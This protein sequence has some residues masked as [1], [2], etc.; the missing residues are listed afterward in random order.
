MWPVP[1]MI[2]IWLAPESPWWLLRRGRTNEAKKS[3]RR[4]TAR[5]G[6]VPFKPDETISMMI[7]T[8]EMEK[9][10]QAGTSY[11]DLFKGVNLRRA[12]IVCVTWMIQT[13]CAAIFMGSL[14]G[15]R[16]RKSISL[17]MKMQDPNKE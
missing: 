8:N 7:H 1:F 12:E 13:L 6:V 5:N 15:Y 17:E 10:V 11:L 4:L 3:L 14:K 2:G 9:E 16:W